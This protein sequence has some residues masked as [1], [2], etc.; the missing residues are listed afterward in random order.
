MRR[1]GCSPVNAKV[2]GEASIVLGASNEPICHCIPSTSVFRPCSRRVIFLP[3]NPCV[4]SLIGIE[5]KVLWRCETNS[6]Q[7][8]LFC[9]S[10]HLEPFSRP[11]AAPINSH[12]TI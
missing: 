7:Q 2:L 8:P 11:C 5:R 1:L 9:A 3:R 4:H 10:K 6:C 12:V